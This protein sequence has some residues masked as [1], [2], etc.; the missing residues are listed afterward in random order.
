MIFVI[1]GLRL[2][3][4]LRGHYEREAAGASAE[5]IATDEIP[6]S[7]AESV[8]ILWQVRTLRRIWYSLPFLASSIIGLVT[9]T[10]LYYEQV[11]HLDQRAR[12]FIGAATEPAAVIGL[13]LGIPLAS[14]LMLR[15][16]GLG[17]RLLAVVGVFVAGAF[18]LFALTPYLWLAIAMNI[19]ISGIVS[20]LAPGHLRVAR[21]SASRQ[22]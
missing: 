22:R 11:F 6:P 18:M 5:A 4:P 13:S 3:E 8:R 1:L 10:A 21:A 9:L 7:F 20:L 19:L 2:K 12:G 17:L 14:R 15:D 16:P